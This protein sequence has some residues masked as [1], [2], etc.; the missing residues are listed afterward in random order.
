MSGPYIFVINE[1]SKCNANAKV[2][3]CV[4]LYPTDM[5]WVCIRRLCVEIKRLISPPGPIEMNYNLKCILFR[6][7]LDMI[8]RSYST[9]VWTKPS[10]S[11]GGVNINM[12]TADPGQ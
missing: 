3:E 11:T 6:C 10:L 12:A 2:T 1:Q 9:S 8:Q 7:K 5:Y 4:Y